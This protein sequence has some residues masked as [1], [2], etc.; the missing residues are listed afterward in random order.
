MASEELKAS[1]RGYKFGEFEYY[2]IGSTTINQLKKA[3]LIPNKKY[4]HH[5]RK[6][7]ALI[8][9]KQ[10][11]NKIKI[12]AT[13]EFKNQGEFKSNSDKIAAVK[14]CNDI[15]SLLDAQIG[16]I[17]DFEET[18]WINPNQEN[19]TN[20]YEDNSGTIRSYSYILDVNGEILNL[21]FNI[22]NNDYFSKEM[23]PES[24]RE[25]YDT[26]KIL[27]FQ[28]S[29]NNSQIKPIEYIDPLP[30]AKS[31]WQD[32]W[33]ATGKSPEKCL[34]NVIE[35][36]IFKFL[37]DLE[38]LTNP[39]NFEYLYNLYQSHDPEYVLNYYATN[40]RKK[41]YSLFPADPDDKTTI[42][43]GTI[44]VNENGDANLTQ[45]NL[46]KGTINKFYQ[47]EKDYGKF[48][49]IDKDFKTRLYETFLK[50]TKGFKG[51]GQYF[52][53]RKIVQSI[54][55]MSGIEEMKKN[56][57]VCDPFCGVGGFLLESVNMY[58]K[59]KESYLPKKGS[60]KPTIILN[61][62]DKGSE[63]DEERT[64]ILAKANMLIYLSDIIIKHPT[65]TK[66]FSRIFNDTFTLLKTNLGT[67][68]LLLE[69][70]NK[71]DLI[72]TNPPYVTSGKRVLNNEI[73][74]DNMLKSFYSVN[75]IGIESLAIE[76]IIK[77]LKKSGYAF[78]VIPF[79]V[80]N[81]IHDTRLRRFIIEACYLYGIISLPANTFY[82]TPQKT[83]IMILKKKENRVDKQDFPVFTYIVNC[84]GETLDSNRFEIS[85]NDLPKMVSQ[86]NQFKGSPNTFNTQ[87]PKCRV[88]DFKKFEPEKTWAIDR[89]LSDTTRIELGIQEKTE[90]I[91]VRNLKKEL[92]NLQKQLDN[93]IKSIDSIAKS[94]KYKYTEIELNTLFDL[95]VKTNNSKFTKTFIN[96]NKG[97][98]PVYGAT[99]SIESISYGKVKD[100][101][102]NIKYFENC[103]TWNI[104]GYVGKVFYRKGKF[105]LSEKVIPLIL[106][107]EYI[108][109]CD[110]QYLKYALENEANKLHL[111]Y[112]NKAGKSRI[113]NIVIKI[114]TKYGKIDLTAQKELARKYEKIEQ[115]MAKLDITLQTIQKKSVIV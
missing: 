88:H 90:V 84:I 6:P 28:L 29:K 91:N 51:L 54:I 7:D 37:S 94:K 43:N 89:W 65:L 76:W 66:E 5:T 49:H 4:K 57:R 14:Q 24:T 35:I 112:S 11:P 80:L 3:K 12:I 59:I 92:G 34:Y 38:V 82:S 107:D 10:N 77:H 64:I 103:L 13:I 17:T 86:F 39:D 106:R 60:I 20:R 16:I 109:I 78:I 74:E 15:A 87:D 98:I 40:C 58:K 19:K 48:I 95:S 53:P 52:T 25:I 67:L 50:Q 99:Q 69:E 33:V 105:S 63:R 9:D 26:I 30:L 23:M 72:L 55:R 104:D 114:P 31:I 56:E 45:S 85:E 83:Y 32:I 115:I 71:Y 44:F 21:P 113:K 18:L 42:I 100:N 70:D 108:N 8:I 46:F 96:K 111:D 47:Y 62:F 2:I 93:N 79:G 41:I 1:Q 22:K 68:G 36:F 97:D 61:G 110:Y 73:N 81:R 101:L 27:I 75:S 102:K